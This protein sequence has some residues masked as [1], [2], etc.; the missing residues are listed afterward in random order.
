MLIIKINNKKVSQ[1]TAREYLGQR[2]F[3]ERIQA[4]KEYSIEEPGEPCT[5]MDGMEML[6]IE[7]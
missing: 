7:A 5:W 4:A 1:K 3:E 2:R 6:Y